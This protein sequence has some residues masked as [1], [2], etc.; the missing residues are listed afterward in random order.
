[1]FELVLHDQAGEHGAGEAVGPLGQNVGHAHLVG[2]LDEIL[3]AAVAGDRH[4]ERVV[5]VLRTQATQ[6]RREHAGLHVPEVSGE[7]F[8]FLQTRGGVQ[9]LPGDGRRGVLVVLS[10]HPADEHCVPGAM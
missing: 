8:A 4:I 1:M 3:Q 10:G 2:P 6:L 9:D 5:H 7:L